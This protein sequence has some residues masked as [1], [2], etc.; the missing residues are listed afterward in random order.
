MVEALVQGTRP[1]FPAIQGGLPTVVRVSKR[2]NAMVKMIAAT[3]ATSC[4]TGIRMPAILSVPEN[5]DCGSET[6]FAE[7]IQNAV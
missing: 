6:K 1:F 5:D 3:P 2:C 7:K 4:G